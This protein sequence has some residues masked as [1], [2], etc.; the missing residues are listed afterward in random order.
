MSIMETAPL[1][2]TRKAAVLLSVLGEEAAATILQ[3]LSEDELQRVTD[4]VAGLTS[5]PFDTALEV[6]E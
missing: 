2:G 3:N 6:L 1:S 5:V 4:E